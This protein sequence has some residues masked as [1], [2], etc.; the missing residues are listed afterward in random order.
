MTS[1]FLRLIET[2]SSEVFSPLVCRPLCSPDLMWAVQRLA[3]TKAP[4][5][6]EPRDL[7]RPLGE[8]TPP[9]LA[10]RAHRGPGLPAGGGTRLFVRL[11]QIATREA[12]PVRVTLP[13]LPCWKG[14]AALRALLRHR[15]HT[16]NPCQHYVFCRGRAA[17]L[18][19]EQRGDV[20]KPSSPS[21]VASCAKWTLP[22]PRRSGCMPFCFELL[23]ATRPPLRWRQVVGHEQ[24]NPATP[25]GRGKGKTFEPWSARREEGSPATTLSTPPC[26][27]G[28]SLLLGFEDPNPSTAHSRIDRRRWKALASHID[29]TEVSPMT[30]HINP[31]ACCRRGHLRRRWQPGG[32]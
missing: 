15:H 10:R 21:C 4:L 3:K 16:W 30:T 12:I 6:H 24:E 8:M 13:A 14:T 20:G 32:I 11:A 9:S 27:R 7:G 1:C 22:P 17:P 26:L 29:S 23:P 2:V 25:A 18:S 28:D 31:V 5:P 19:H